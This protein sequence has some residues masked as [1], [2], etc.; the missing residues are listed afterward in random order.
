MDKHF[1]GLAAA[2]VASG[3]IDAALFVK[4]V[5]LSDGDEKRGRAL[6]IKLRADELAQE[7]KR[8][9]AARIN[10][11]MNSDE[12]MQ[13]GAKAL[14]DML[15]IVPLAVLVIVIAIAASGS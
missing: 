4:S 1:F 7:Y 14:R 5:A 15:W 12:D 2:E 6:Y 13:R 9:E 8:R 3:Q 10:A 11:A